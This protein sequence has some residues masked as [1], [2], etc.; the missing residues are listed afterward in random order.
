VNL[1]LKIDLLPQSARDAIKLLYDQG[2]TWKEIEDR[3]AL[4]FS[5]KWQTDGAG[6]INWETLDL[7]VLEHFPALRL[8]KST[9]HRW[10]DLK[11][12]QA[13]K[14]VLAESEKAREWAAAFAGKDLPNANAAVINALRDQVFGL[15]EDVSK[16]DKSAFL[17][18]LGDLTL[19]MTRMQRVELQARRVGVDEKKVEALL[20]RERIAQ[21][22]LEAETDRAVSKLK[23]G[24]L[25]VA[26]IN[27]LR[28][29]VFGL[30]PVGA[31]AH[32]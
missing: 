29:R 7:K 26:D 21:K 23:K 30:P 11:V 8:P 15:M 2:A 32:G 4:A 28:E 16:A 31:A 17:A 13:R 24:E 6:F 25:T 12:S 1:P 5:E 14:Q 9:L 3:S 27:R 18:A 19:A 20:A 22:K 10:F